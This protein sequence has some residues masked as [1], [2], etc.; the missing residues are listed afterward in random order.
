[1][2]QCPDETDEIEVKR[3]SWDNIR[4]TIEKTFSKYEGGVTGLLQPAR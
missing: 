3:E 1:M 2:W 4:Y